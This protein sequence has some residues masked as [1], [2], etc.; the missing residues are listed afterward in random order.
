MTE[1]SDEYLSKIEVELLAG[2]SGSR[3]NNHLKPKTFK[4]PKVLVPIDGLPILYRVINTCKE[5]GLYDIN[6]ILTKSSSEDIINYIESIGNNLGVWIFDN[7]RSISYELLTIANETK[8]DSKLKGYGASNSDKEYM[9]VLDADNLYTIDFLREVIEKSEEEFKYEDVGVVYFESKMNP[10]PSVWK[11]KPENKI[12]ER[13]KNHAKNGY[14][15]AAT[16]FRKEYLKML[17]LEDIIKYDILG[18]QY[19]G[20]V[21]HLIEIVSSIPLEIMTVD[22]KVKKTKVKARFY[23]LKGE[24]G[25]LDYPTHVERLERIIKTSAEEKK[26]TTLDEYI[27]I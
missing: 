23:K 19:Y 15:V 2:G 14:F 11:F 18:K 27:T 10:A 5:V 3:F 16:V 9:L 12:Q 13:F 25:H 20:S 26:D 4:I 17:G 7:K 22:G 24:I 8:S 6:L 21:L 1:I